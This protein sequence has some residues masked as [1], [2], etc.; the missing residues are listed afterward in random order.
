MT[1]TMAAHC[2]CRVAFALCFSIEHSGRSAR[3]G[4]LAIVRRLR[5]G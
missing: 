3:R 4:W 5:G 1:M 2:L